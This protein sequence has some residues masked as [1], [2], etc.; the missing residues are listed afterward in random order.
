MYLSIHYLA[1][2]ICWH[3]FWKQTLCV[4]IY[5]CVCVCVCAN[6]FFTIISLGLNPRARTMSHRDLSDTY[7]VEECRWQ[8]LFWVS[9]TPW[10]VMFYPW[11]GH[12]LVAS[13]WNHHRV[14]FLPTLF[15]EYG[16]SRVDWFRYSPKSTKLVG[17]F[18]HF[19]WGCLS[20]LCLSATFLRPMQGSL[21]L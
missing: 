2:L 18:G 21:F 19:N 14:L 5:M 9:L 15:Y 1:M 17:S 3:I 7:W 11:S 6:L 8:Y 4:C 10:E 12:P 16:N 20:P 13:H